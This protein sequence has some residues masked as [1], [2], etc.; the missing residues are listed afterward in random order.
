MCHHHHYFLLQRDSYRC[1]MK[2]HSKDTRI[3][4]GEIFIVELWNSTVRI[5]GYK[6]ISR[7]NS[8]RCAMKQHN[9]EKI[10]VYRCAMKQHCKRKFKPQH[11]AERRRHHHCGMIFLL[12]YVWVRVIAHQ[13]SNAA[14]NPGVIFDSQFVLKEQ[15]NKFCQPACGSD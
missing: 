5:Q 4:Q 6:D 15:V 3:F 10:Y 9:K 8:Y 1:V 14:R 7:R 12:H 11:C 2:Q 13:F